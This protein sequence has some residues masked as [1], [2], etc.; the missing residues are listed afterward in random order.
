MTQPQILF[1]DPQNPVTLSGPVGPLEAVVT[2]PLKESKPIIG[3]ICHPHPLYGGTM[4]NKVVTTVARAFYDL[5]L[6]SLRFNY[7]GVEKSAGSYGSGLGEVEDLLAV[8]TWVRQNFPQYTLWLAGFSFGSYVAA[9]AA[10]K[11]DVAQLITIAPA[12]T[13]FDFK[14]IAQIHC[15]W[16]LLMGEEDEIVPLSAV[17]NWLTTLSTPIQ[18]IFF[19]HVGHFFHGHLVQLR[20]ALKKA[21]ITNV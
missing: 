18:T 7:R 2:P 9:Q 4:H 6:W 16:L 15:P 13:H 11:E 12:V 20:E 3:I 5:G 17:K 21:L 8:L 14:E 10:A 19:P 1:P